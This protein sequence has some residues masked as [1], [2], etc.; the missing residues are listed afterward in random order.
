MVVVKSDKK[1]FFSKG[2]G[3][4]AYTGL[5]VYR[6]DTFFV[7][8]KFGPCTLKMPTFRMYFDVLYYSVKY[9]Q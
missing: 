5:F 3:G 7:S 6:D 2:L 4:T 8:L 9:I 1:W